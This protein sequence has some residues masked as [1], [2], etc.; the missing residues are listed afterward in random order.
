ME[1]LLTVIV[2]WLSIN[3]GLPATHELPSVEL[4]PPAKMAA[5]R[6]RGLASD[7]Q[8]NAA[9]E[10]G[11]AAPPEFGQEVYALYDTQRRII[12]LHE[13][14]SSSRPAD[15]SVLVHEM[16]HHLQTAADEKF[17]CP[18]EREKDAYKAQREWLAMFGRS[19]EQEFEIDG[20]TVLVRTNC[21]F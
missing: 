5:V 18:Q 15:V 4:V 16:V 7:R 9:I 12:Y 19:L 13:D 21:G 20:M 14:W 11:R 10:A 17:A 8:P 1:T 6:F 3:F 2:T